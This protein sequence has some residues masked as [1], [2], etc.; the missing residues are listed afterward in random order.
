MALAKKK[1]RT[2]PFAVP[3]AYMTDSLEGWLATQGCRDIDIVFKD[4]LA[5]MVPFCDIYLNDI[6]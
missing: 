6:L 4:Q 2:P 5:C 1:P 3:L